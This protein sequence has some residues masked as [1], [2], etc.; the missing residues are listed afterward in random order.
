MYK[1][2]GWKFNEEGAQC[3][4][5]HVRQSV[6]MYDIMQDHIIKVS[7][8]FIEDNTNV[9]DIGT[10]TGELLSKIP[11]NDTCSYIGIDIEEPMIIKA[12]EKL[13]ER[14]NL[15]V[16]DIL[17]YNIDN[18]SFI[19]MML[20]LQFIKHR[21][22][23]RALTNVYNA[24]NKGGAFILVDKIK[25]PVLDIHDIYNDLYYDFKRNQGLSDTEIIDK[26]V[27]L[28]GFQKCITLQDNLDLLHQAGFD[29]MDILFKT[30]NFVVILCIK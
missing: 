6:P 14:Y 2:Y 4:D 13:D 3:F 26:N 12:R 30:N 25:T 29:K 16:R 19:T 24:L 22:K 9:L 10:S 11:Y 8:F 28:R 1:E 18:C 20:V 23:L 7:K 15:Q 27:S 21:D 5:I 17:N